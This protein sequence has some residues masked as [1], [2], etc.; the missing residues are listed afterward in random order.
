VAYDEELAERVRA[1]LDDEPGLTERKMFGGIGWMLEG[2]MA[3][4]MISTGLLVRL[5]QDADAALSEPH[6]SAPM[7]GS[8]VMK[9]FVVVAP[10]GV[11]TDE[12]LAAWVARGSDVARSLP[13]K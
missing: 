3:V 9:G 6:A 10:E 8:R 7:M 4:G 2:N 13:P 12:Q 5:G 11:E 1:Q